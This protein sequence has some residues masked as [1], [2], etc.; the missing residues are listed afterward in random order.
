M[1]FWFVEMQEEQGEA[2]I[3]K[4][5]WQGCSLSPCLLNLYSAKAINEIKE[6]SKNIGV[7]VQGKTIQMLPFADNIALLANTERELE[8]ALDVTDTV[9]IEYN[10][11][12]ASSLKIWTKSVH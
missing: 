10:I 12:Q 3:K 7:I 4:K 6:K 9:F 5:K 1:C 2:S 8:D 11:L